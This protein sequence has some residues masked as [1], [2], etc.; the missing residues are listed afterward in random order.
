MT[1]VVYEMP[2]AQGSKKHVGNGIMVESSA[3]VRPWRAAVGDAVRQQHSAIAKM[4]GPLWCRIVF[5][6]PKPKSAP[7]R[8]RTWPNK[9]PDLD[10]LL[11]ATFDALTLAGVWCDDAQVVSCHVTKRYPGEGADALNTPGAFIQ[12]AEERG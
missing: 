11:R 2:A 9:K 1:I 3:K 5:T 10:K 8:L 7:K 4:E 6:L 12:I